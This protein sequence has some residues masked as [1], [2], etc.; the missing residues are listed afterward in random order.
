[1]NCIPK[2][3][4]LVLL[5]LAPSPGSMALHK[6]YLQRK[7]VPQEPYVVWTVAAADTA[8]IGII[9]GGL[10]NHSDGML[11]TVYEPPTYRFNYKEAA[12]DHYQVFVND[13]PDY[14]FFMYRHGSLGRQIRRSPLAYAGPETTYGYFMQQYPDGDLL[15][16]YDKDG[17]VVY[18]YWM[19]K[20]V[21]FFPVSE[22]FEQ[23][24]EHRIEEL[25]LWSGGQ[26]FLQRMWNISK[27]F[28][29]WQVDTTYGCLVNDK[30]ER[31]CDQAL[32]DSFIAQKTLNGTYTFMLKE[33]I[34]SG[35]YRLY[36]YSG[37]ALSVTFEKNHFTGW[38][39]AQK[40]RRK[41]T[42]IAGYAPSLYPIKSRDEAQEYLEK[43]LLK[44]K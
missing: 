28:C 41:W 17:H 21:S 6:I 9:P 29:R 23:L 39:L 25:M 18:R 4:L 40:R 15:V 30:N 27:D 7:W 38:K 33:P 36:R 43:V 42:T 12:D 8:L 19:G 24:N 20:G 44:G 26:Q 1:M 11:P 14:D 2:T 34:D 31:T 10:T 13:T 37:T 22:S 35:N 3:L 16:Y 5:L 32:T